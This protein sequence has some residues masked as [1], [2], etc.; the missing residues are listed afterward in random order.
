MF[1]IDRIKTNP[2]RIFR[3]LMLPVGLAAFTAMAIENASAHDKGCDGN[4]VPLAVKLDCCSKADE[5]QLSPGQISRGPNEEYIVRFE[6]YVFVIPVNKALPSSDHC[7][8]IFFPNVWIN[9]VGRD[10]ATPD[11]YCFLTPLD[12]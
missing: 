6:N 8:H 4:P 11:V 3:L 5:H 7:S 10:P 1:L 9:N 2:L 12:F